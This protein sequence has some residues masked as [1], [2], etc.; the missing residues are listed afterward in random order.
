MLVLIFVAMAMAILLRCHKDAA[1]EYKKIK[2]GTLLQQQLRI[3]SEIG[4]G[5]RG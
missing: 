2:R 1:L 3:T 5:G 4:G